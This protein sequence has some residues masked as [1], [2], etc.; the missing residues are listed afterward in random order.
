MFIKFSTC[1]ILFITSLSFSQGYE[2]TGVLNDENNVPIAFANVVL[3]EK[4]S[5]K[6]LQGSTTDENGVFVID[7][8]KTGSYQIKIS[9]LGY[10]SFTEDLLIKNN[11]DLGTIILE[12]S[13]EILDDVT[14]VA[15]RPTVKR[16]VDRLI[17]NVENSTLSNDNLLGVLKHTPGVLV[18]DGAISIKQATPIIYINDK[19]VY[20]S[21]SEVLQLLEATSANDVKSIEVITNPPAKY[22]AEG[23]AVI[24][25]VTTKNVISGYRG[26]VFGDYKQGFEYPK[27]SAGTSHFFKTKKLN[28]YINYS[29]SP[30]KDYRNLRDDVNFIEN[31]KIVSI[32]NTDYN[33]TRESA[34]QNINAH[35]DYALSN[36]SEIGFSTSMLLAPRNGVRTDVNSLTAIYDANKTLDSTFNTINKSVDEIYNLAFTLDYAYKIGDKGERISSNVHHTNYDFS[37]FQDVNTNYN[38]PDGS[39]IRNNHFQTFSRQRIKLYTGQIDYELPNK[40][41]DQF[42]AGLKYARIDSQSR[43]KQHLV[44]ETQP[45]VA[46]DNYDTFNYSED[47]YAG[48]VSVSEDW[49]NWSL[50]L[51]IRGEYTNLKGNSLSTGL[52]NEQAYFKLFP[53]LY[54]L[55]KLNDIN[56]LYV[57]YKRSIYRPK[58]NELNPFEF[59]L[60][61]NTISSGNPNLL[62]Q[63]DD[64]VILGY[65]F[66]ES[67][68]FEI[69]YRYEDNVNIEFI[70]QDNENRLIRQNYTNIDYGVSYG[71]DFTTY[72]TIT[73][74]WNLYI[75][76]SYFYNENNYFTKENELLQNDKWTFYG[77][78]INYFS[79]LKDKS[80]T[81]DLSFIY[82]SSYIDGPR[83]IS[84]RAG[85]D[86]SVRKSFWENRA[87]LSLGVSDV[88][89][90]QNFTTDTRYLDQD[91]AS[92]STMENRLFTVGFN[93]KFGNFRLKTNEKSID[94]QER[95]RLSHRD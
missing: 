85:L 67:Y 87:S 34:N 74:H 17:F 40:F 91:I 31:D 24:N 63:I 82:I 94:T 47:N 50:K 32:W 88:F 22:D 45:L 81:T 48:Y 21:Q 38:F 75:L 65:T 8:I 6:P 27:F 39:L 86:F 80:L 46:L 56:Q 41:G 69:Y 1:F 3:V 35:I 93:Y 53:S 66:D 15:K 12:T 26:S 2:I 72:K 29:I 59:F 19:R 79:F 13:S 23:G 83:E 76:S 64:Q 20:L 92:K 73:K 68:T 55:H 14:V 58:Y 11:T 10:K 70:Y 18:H 9:F 37:I 28:T 43:L 5:D 89:N 52:I 49:E 25:I 84:A 61:D 90:T 71:L 44:N 4:Q 7:N 78:I 60:N 30:R 77:Q 33:R 42:E 62:P 95:E 51:G 54:I 57:N 16:Q 36:K